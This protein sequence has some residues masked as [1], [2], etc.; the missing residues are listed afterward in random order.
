HYLARHMDSWRQA[1]DDLLTLQLPTD[2]PRP[3]VQ[4][5]HGALH[6]LA[7]P[8]ALSDDLKELSRREGVTLYMTLVAA[9]VTLLHR[10][11]GQD[12]IVIGTVTGSRDRPE[13]EKLMGF[14]LNT[15]ALRTDLAGDPTFRA[16]LERVRRATL[17]VQEHR[18]VPFELVVRDLH[19]QRTFTQNPLFQVMF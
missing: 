9:L 10:Y 19:P 12:D 2:Y 4:T 7:F 17:E 11:A 15:I 8:L 6:R 14:F 3:A 16:V 13:I 1:P 18:D 5:F